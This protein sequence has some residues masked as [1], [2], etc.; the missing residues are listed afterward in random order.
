MGEH[1]CQF[2]FATHL[3][4]VQIEV[5][6]Q[7]NFSRNRQRKRKMITSGIFIT[8]KLK[9]VELVRD[10]EGMGKILEVCSIYYLQKI[11]RETEDAGS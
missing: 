7:M 9:K 6:E 2:R 8:K 4:S 5:L 1:K 3:A 10:R 11:K